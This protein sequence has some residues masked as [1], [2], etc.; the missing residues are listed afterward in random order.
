MVIVEFEFEFGFVCDFG[1][2]ICVFLGCVDLLHIMSFLPKDLNFVNHSS[3]IG[4]K[5]YVHLFCHIYRFQVRVV[6]YLNFV[7][8]AL[9]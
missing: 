3:Y 8:D 5:E 9:R 2:L 6:W 4:W 1:F 7:V